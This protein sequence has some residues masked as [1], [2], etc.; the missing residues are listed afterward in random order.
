MFWHIY[1]KIFHVLST[2]RLELRTHCS[3]TDWATTRNHANNTKVMT[4]FTRESPKSVFSTTE[5]FQRTSL[6]SA[7]ICPALIKHRWNNILS[8]LQ[9]SSTNGCAWVSC[10]AYNAHIGKS[11]ICLGYKGAPMTNQSATDQLAQ[12]GWE[13]QKTWCVPHAWELIRWLHDQ[14][15]NELWGEIG[16]LVIIKQTFSWFWWCYYLEL[17]AKILPSACS[18]FSERSIF[19][20]QNLIRSL[21]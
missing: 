1:Q 17:F 6:P 19:S 9:E 15:V 8:Y 13:A 21:K 18:C 12:P 5:I 10:C 20:V 11:N 7:Q 3:L 14:G 4:S 2:P 16:L